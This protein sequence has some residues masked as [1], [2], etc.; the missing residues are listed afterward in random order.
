M[1]LTPMAK[2]PPKSDNVTHGQGSLEWS[3]MIVDWERVGEKCR[4]VY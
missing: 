3:V 1:R 2:A 4:R